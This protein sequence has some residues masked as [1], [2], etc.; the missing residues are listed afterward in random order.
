MFGP[1]F[2]EELEDAGL[3][4]LPFVWGDD[5]QMTGRENLTAEQNAR[6]DAVIAAHDPTKPLRRP[7]AKAVIVD[8]LHAAGKL[9][10]A[11]VALD[12]ADLYTRE[13]WNTRAAI[14]SDDPAALALLAA[15][16]ADPAVIMAL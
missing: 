14:Y 8:R 6:L 11:R 4:G 7:V 15:I 10:A 13:R 12:A 1:R 5:G 2:G 3:P 16:G 9:D